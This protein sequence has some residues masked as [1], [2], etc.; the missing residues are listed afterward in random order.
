[1][2]QMLLNV[3]GVVNRA[4]V[5]STAVSNMAATD[6]L[7]FSVVATPP[8]DGVSGGYSF[9]LKWLNHWGMWP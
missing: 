7:R 3:A 5:H 6:D 4:L 8:F 2:E 9:F 1:M